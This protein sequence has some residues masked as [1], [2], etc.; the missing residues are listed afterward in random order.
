MAGAAS[1]GA[2]AAV[3]P[4]RVVAGVRLGYPVG[5]SCCLAGPETASR[6]GGVL[7]IDDSGDGK[8]GTKT[9]YVGRRWAGPAYESPA[10]AWPPGPR[11]GP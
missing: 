7:V 10:T 6:E 4:V 9:A 8:D 3:L 2:A 11:C 5:W 1:G